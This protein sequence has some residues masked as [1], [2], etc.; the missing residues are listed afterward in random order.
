MTRD[1]WYDTF[2]DASR[3]DVLRYAAAT[4]ATAGLAGTAAGSDATG[5]Q[6]GDETDD[7]IHPAFGFPALSEDVEPPVEPDH[8]V[9]MQTQPREDRPNPEFYFD[10]TGVYVEPGDTVRFDAVSPF[11]NVMAYHPGFRQTRRV[12]EDVPPISSPLF[13]EGAYWLYTF[14]QPGVYDLYCGP[15]EFLGMVVRVVAGEASGPGAEP[16]PEPSAPGQ[17]PVGGAD[18]ENAT[19]GNATPSGQADNATNAT[20]GNATT[21][22][23][24]PPEQQ[25][26]PP[27]GLAATILR[28]DPMSPENIVD[29]GTV[30][31]EDIPDEAKDFGGGGGPA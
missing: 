25:L 12:P 1:H 27:T 23:G 30:A 4:G 31:W 26:S 7:Q 9:E 13:A 14:D 16:V 2:A 11:H 24:G 29:Q 17:G 5:W 21:G 6:E 20:G 8:A 15:H 22:Q 3:R 18:G 10:P 28:S 19:V